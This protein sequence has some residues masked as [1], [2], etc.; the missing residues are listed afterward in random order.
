VYSLIATG[1]QTKVMTVTRKRNH[2]RVVHGLDGLQGRSAL[3]SSIFGV[4]GMSRDK[5]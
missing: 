3:V 2:D 5:A 1:M 4:W